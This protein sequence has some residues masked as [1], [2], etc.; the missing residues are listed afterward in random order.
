MVARLVWFAFGYVCSCWFGVGSVV[1]LASPRGGLDWI[2]I[3]PSNKLIV[4]TVMGISLLTYP[5]MYSWPPILL[6]QCEPACVSNVG[7]GV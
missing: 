5:V 6:S 7:F 2:E 1:L 3:V 4:K